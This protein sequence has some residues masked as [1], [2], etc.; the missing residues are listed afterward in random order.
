MCDFGAISGPTA[1]AL[2]GLATTATAAGVSAYGAYAQ[3]QQQNKIAKYNATMADYEAADAEARGKIEADK[4]RL[5]TRQLISAQRAAGGATGAVVDTGSLLDV[6]T[7]TARFGELDALAIQQ[8]ARRDA[9][10][11]R[12]S[13]NLAR[14][15]QSSALLAGGT[16]LLTSAPSVA[17]S[18]G[19]FSK[20]YKENGWKR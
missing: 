14:L 13:G 1:V 8:N 3:Q 18:Y 17:T 4:K 2:I 9:W 10:R 6:T 16:S 11:M 12:E 19:N 7:D 15:S 5:Q 20:S